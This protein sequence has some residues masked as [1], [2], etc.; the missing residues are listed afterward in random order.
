MLKAEFMKSSRKK[1]QRAQESKSLFVPLAPLRGHSI[2]QVGGVAERHNDPKQAP[3][4]AEIQGHNGAVM[5]NPGQSESQSVKV[6]QSGNEG[7]ISL[8]KIKVIQGNS[9]QI[10]VIQGI[11]KH[12]FSQQNQTDPARAGQSFARRTLA[13]SQQW[14]ARSDAPCRVESQQISMQ[15][16]LSPTPVKSCLRQ[17]SARLP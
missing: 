8:Q 6:D 1:A 4:W 16:Q 9:S 11:L 5:S 15:L 17:A 10:K 13:S 14:R 12:F 7:L 3:V 2:W